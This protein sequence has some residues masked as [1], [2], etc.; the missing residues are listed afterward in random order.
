MSSPYKVTLV[1]LKANALGL[2]PAGE[3]IELG[4]LPVEEICRLAGNL[5]LLSTV[6][7]AKAEP[8]IIVHRGEKG[9]RIAVH[10]GRLCMHKSTSTFDE[11]W[12]VENARALAKLPPFHADP[13]APPATQRVKV[14]ESGR[15]AGLRTISEAFGLFVL[16]VGLI[17]VGFWFGVP[18]KKLSD[19][20][21]DV[22]EVTSDSERA[23]VFSAVA[24]SYATGKKTGAVVKPGES[25]VMITPEGRVSLGTIG[26]DGKPVAP[27]L[28]EQARAARKGNLAALVTSFGVIAEFPPD[29][30]YVGSFRW[31]RLM[32]N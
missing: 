1:Q 17:L 12:S 27:R 8:G 26:Q 23:S 30:V 3:K 28:Q 10:S 9:W 15:F 14:G 18:H 16:G 21:S 25:I 29:G 22:V 13:V 7:D 32:T 6:A 31:R 11:Y 4:Y 24:G 5:Q 19:L 20:P 2:A